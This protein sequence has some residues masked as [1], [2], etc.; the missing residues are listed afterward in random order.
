MR[1]R[2]NEK[3]V[4]ASSRSTS[5]RSHVVGVVPRAVDPGRRG[6]RVRRGRGD[7]RDR[8]PSPAEAAREAS[9]AAVAQTAPGGARRRSDREPAVRVRTG[10]HR[11]TGDRRDGRARDRRVAFDGVDRRATEPSRGGTGRRGGV[12]R[13][14]PRRVPR[15]A[16]DVLG[17]ERGAGPPHVRSNARRD[18]V[19]IARRRHG[20]RDGDR[21][22]PLVRARCDPG[23]PRRRGPTRRRRPAERRPRL[24][25]HDPAGASCRAGRGTRRSSCTR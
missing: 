7:R 15:G 8:G 10:A 3:R 2:P 14:T 25:Q 13:P 6:G 21:R 23:G 1:G 12:P 5:S 17:L 19:G 22:R 11:P 9:G 16:R 20:D 18:G 24:R 4:C